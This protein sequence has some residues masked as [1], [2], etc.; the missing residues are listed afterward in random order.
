MQDSILPAV[1]MLLGVALTAIVTWLIAQR[2]IW[3]QHVTAERAKWR[4]NIRALALEVHNA[5]MCGD[6]EKLGRLQNEFRVLLDP[7]DCHDQAILNSMVMDETRQERQEQ[8]EEFAGRISLLLKHDWERVKMEAG[9][10]LYRWA[11]E[12]RRLPWNEGDASRARDVC[13]AELRWCKKYRIRPTPALVIVLA[14]TMG[15]L[16][17]VYNDSLSTLTGQRGTTGASTTV[18]AIE[19][20]SGTDYR[21]AERG[22]EDSVRKP[23]DGSSP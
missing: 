12:P 15:I 10:F 23:G 8:A 11:V 5:I 6:T 16:A 17:C 22:G 13:N 2:Q 19:Y 7:F 21:N 20:T 18:S 14:I 3:M 4:E 1:P 9:F